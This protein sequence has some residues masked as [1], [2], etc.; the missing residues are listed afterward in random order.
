MSRSSAT[1]QGTTKQSTVTQGRIKRGR[2]KDP[3]RAPAT[4]KPLAAAQAEDM[5]SWLVLALVYAFMLSRFD[6]RLLVSDSILT[7]GDSASWYQVLKTLK[8]DFLPQ[9]RLFGFSQANFFGY[10]EG[11][12]YFILPFLVAALLGFLVPLGVA[13]KI[14]TVAGGFALPLS[15]FFAASSISG[16]KRSG[17]IDAALSLLFLLNES[18]S[19]FGGNWLSTFA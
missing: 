6:L 4:L 14:A 11:Q 12:H 9:G 16:R 7:G 18:Y 2:T 19:I 17:A 3:Q 5:V 1:K 8:E 13:L 15:M 10:L